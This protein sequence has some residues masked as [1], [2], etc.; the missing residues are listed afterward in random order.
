[1]VVSTV[2]AASSLAACSCAAGRCGS[3]AWVLPLLVLSYGVALLWL[4]VVWWHFGVLY[5]DFLLDQ[6]TCGLDRGRR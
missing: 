2:T 6:C 1:M 3:P 4:L 5:V